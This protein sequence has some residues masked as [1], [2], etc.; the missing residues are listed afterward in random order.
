MLMTI[1]GV[2]GSVTMLFAG[3]S[4]QHSISTINDRQFGQI[5]HYDMIVA[6]SDSVTR[7]QR[8]E[9]GD[10]LEADAVS[11]YLPVHYEELSRVAGRNQDR[12]SIKLIVPRD[13][14]E[15]RT[16]ISPVERR[17]GRELTLTGDGC[18]I[19]E[20]LSTLLGVRSGDSFTVS[21]AAGNERT[22]TVSGIC[23]MYTGH[24]LFMSSEYYEKTFGADYQS[25]AYLL[26]LA[27]SSLENTN[28]QAS[29]FMALGG[30]KGVVQNT[31]MINQIDTIVHALNRIMD[32]LIIVASLLAAVIL[33]NLTNINV[34]ERIR[35]LSTINACV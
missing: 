32:V 13:A 31:T 4:V 12:Q 1:F 24:F 19:S 27:D 2:C 7:L 34:S 8:A 23:E 29:R 3:F 6:E 16:Y 30:V 17:S 26:T 33:Y 18:L 11:S 22:L 9:I 5:L 35:E 21:D 14:G 25:N 10:L 28:R 15:L 20:R